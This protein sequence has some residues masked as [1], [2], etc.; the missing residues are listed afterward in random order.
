AGP[1]DRGGLG[2][3]RAEDGE[4]DTV[5]S[6]CLDRVEQRQPGRREVRRPDVGVHTELHHVLRQAHADQA[7]PALFR[8]AIV[9]SSPRR[10]CSSGGTT[11]RRGP[12]VPHATPPRQPTLRSPPQT[13]PP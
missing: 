8:T 2:Q 11:S 10:A 3:V 13:P 4:F 7:T 1:P 9:A 5:E 6:V 12:I